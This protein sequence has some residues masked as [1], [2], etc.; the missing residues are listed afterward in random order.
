MNNAS[1]HSAPPSVGSAATV[2]YGFTVASVALY[3]SRR[4]PTGWAL[5]ASFPAT[6]FR[7]AQGLAGRWRGAVQ[8]NATGWALSVPV[9]G[10]AGVPLGAIRVL[11]RIHGVAFERT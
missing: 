3:R 1:T 6:S 8:R 7:V 4:S 5:H 11:C 10:A 2:L 9:S